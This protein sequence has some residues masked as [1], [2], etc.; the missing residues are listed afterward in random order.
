[1]VRAADVAYEGSPGAAASAARDRALS[2]AR[3]EARLAVAAEFDA[4]HSVD[5]ARDVGSLRDIVSPS[6]FRGYLIDCLADAR[7]E[8]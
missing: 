6:S 4:I 8:R 5:R 7:R 2:E 1:V 3:L